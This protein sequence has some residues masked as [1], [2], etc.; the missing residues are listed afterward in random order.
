MAS[1]PPDIL[2]KGL[3]NSRFHSKL[4]KEHLEA[5]LSRQESISSLD[6]VKARENIEI[7]GVMMLR[8]PF[9]ESFFMRRAPVFKNKIL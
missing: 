8:V 5:K 2:K 9:R 4:R 7:N 6:A 3:R 1:K